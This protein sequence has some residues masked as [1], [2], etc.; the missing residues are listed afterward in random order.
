MM[1]ISLYLHSQSRRM[2]LLHDSLCIFHV[3]LARKMCFQRVE[4]DTQPPADVY[5]LD[6]ILYTLTLISYV[7][8]SFKDGLFEYEQ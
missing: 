4:S 7:Q 1:Y 3:F 8:Y 5:S 2:K 6:C